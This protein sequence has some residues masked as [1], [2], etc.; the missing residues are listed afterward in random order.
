M[1]FIIKKK[2]KRLA[3]Q[4]EEESAETTDVGTSENNGSE[5]TEPEN[6]EDET[7]SDA[8][9]PAPP[10]GFPIPPHNKNLNVVATQSWVY[11]TLKGF[12][13]WTRFFA[14]QSLQVAGGMYAKRVK[15]GELQGDE[16]YAKK[17]VLI[18]PNGKPAVVYIDELGNLQ[19]QYKYEDVFMYAPKGIDVKSYVYRFPN[20]ISNFAGLTPIE[21]MLNFIP[22]QTNDTKEFNG[23]NC[24]RICEAD[25]GDELLKETFLIKCQETKKIVGLKVVDSDGELVKQ[26]DFAPPEGKIVRRLT[27]NMPCFA[28]T[29]G[30]DDETCY[31]VLP[32]DILDGYG[33]FKPFVPPFLK[34]PVPPPPFFP[35]TP[36]VVPPHVRPTVP[37]NLSP[38][39]F[40]DQE[41]E[42]GDDLFADIGNE[43][44]D[45]GNEDSEPSEDETPNQPLY[46]GPDYQVIYENYHRNTYS[47]VVLKRNDFDT[48]KEQYLM[49]ETV[50]A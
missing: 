36:P 26:L 8:Q 43:F 11:R 38:D 20:I 30:L 17:L 6:Q 15:T 44:A 22:Y 7:S 32:G 16:I 23:V 47:N 14:T 27:I 33:Q 9:I 5:D 37:P 31:V 12:W 13:N 21:T 42:D 49:V 4:N 29:S 28:P 19:R 39:L 3:N 24:P 25:G 45:L 2:G 48:N 50:D 40:D 34:P 35:P 10:P 46:I 1:A 41:I 18:D